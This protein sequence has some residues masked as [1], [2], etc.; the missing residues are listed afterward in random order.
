M[1]LT[2]PL[3]ACQF[4]VSES[5]LR[6]LADLRWLPC[7]AG[8]PAMQGGELC[9]RYPT[10]GAVRAHLVVVASPASELLSSL[11]QRLEPLLVQALITELAVEALYIG[12]LCG[13][14][15]VV[16]QV[17]HAPMP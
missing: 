2:C 7:I 5:G 8:M 6:R 11:V 3:G 10:D 16:D 12:V 4:P 17:P 1:D 13:L 15:R 9:R 14:A